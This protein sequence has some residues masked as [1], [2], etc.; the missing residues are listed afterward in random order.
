MDNTHGYVSLSASV[1]SVPAGNYTASYLA[2]TLQSVVQA[3]FPNDNY[4][5]L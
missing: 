5:Y 4:M 3:T 2:S 1:L